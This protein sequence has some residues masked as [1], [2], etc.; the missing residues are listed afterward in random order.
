MT[1]NLSVHSYGFTNLSNNPLTNPNL[2]E[3]T[4]EKNY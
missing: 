3:T 4:H 2:S 1:T